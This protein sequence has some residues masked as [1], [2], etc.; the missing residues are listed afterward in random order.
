[1]NLIDNSILIKNYSLSIE[2]F[3][4]NFFYSKNISF[5]NSVQSQSSNA[6]ISKSTLLEK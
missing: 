5:K 1:M 3:V 4:K 2:K 6:I